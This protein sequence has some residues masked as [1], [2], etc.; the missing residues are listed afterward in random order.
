M[1]VAAR[2]MGKLA[3]PGNPHTAELVDSEVKVALE[4]LQV[5][6]NE[7]RRFAAVLTIRELARNAPTILYGY[8]TPIFQTIWVALRDPKVLIRE[9]TAEAISQLVQIIGDRDPSFRDKWF[10]RVYQEA[11]VGFEMNTT[12]AVHGSILAL[13][14]LLLKGG[15][16][17][18]QDRRYSHV[19]EKLYGYKDHKEN[20]IRREIVALVPILAGY[21][22]TEFSHGYLHKFM[23]YLQGQLKKE[24]DRSPAFLAI[25]KVTSAVGSSIE[26]YLDGILVFI[27]E[28]LGAKA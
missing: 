1:V 16:F 9:Y 15:M 13:K 25:G 27:R 23:M 21:W 18:Q 14:E 12:D 10:S 8:S 26:A 3:T 6:R 19:C 20:I 2:A 7:G 11:D 17:I 24:K 22:P 4:S 5:E 28:G